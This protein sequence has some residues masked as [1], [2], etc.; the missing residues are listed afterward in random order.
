MKRLFA[1]VLCIFLVMSLCAC[2]ADPLYNGGAATSDETAVAQTEVKKAD[3]T[4]YEKTFDGMQK[5]LIDSELLPSDEKAKTDTLGSLIGAKDKGYRYMLSS[6][7]FIEFYEYDLENLND[8]AK[9]IFSQIEK[10]GTFVVAEGLETLTGVKSSSGKFL[11]VYNAAI[12]FDYDKI[13]AE[14]KQF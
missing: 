1:L 12:S 8:V 14:F 7:A 10:D 5:Y 3:I 2:G 6:S 9:N 11:A 13:I 4:K